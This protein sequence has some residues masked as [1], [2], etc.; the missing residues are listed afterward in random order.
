MRL[1]AHMRLHDVEA[2]LNRDLAYVRV[3]PNGIYIHIMVSTVDT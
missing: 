1:Q 2:V 3:N